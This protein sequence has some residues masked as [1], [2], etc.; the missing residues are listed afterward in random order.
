MTSVLLVWFLPNPL[1]QVPPPLAHPPAWKASEGLSFL[2]RV[3]HLLEFTC[4][5]FLY[6]PRFS[7]DFLNYDFVGYPACFNC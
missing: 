7:K 3:Y 6:D 5:R 4:F 1:Q 2:L